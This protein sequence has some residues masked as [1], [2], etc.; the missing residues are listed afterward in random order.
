[1][2]LAGLNESEKSLVAYDILQR[3]T[4]LFDKDLWE[5]PGPRLMV[6]IDE[7]WQLLR[8]EKEYDAARESVWQSGSCGS[9][10]SM[11]SA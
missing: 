1:M 10:G 6:V 5:G 7:A 4:E 9:A 2:S 11:G 3:L 8:R